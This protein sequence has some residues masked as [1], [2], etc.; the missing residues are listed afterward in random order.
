[1]DVYRA[2]FVVAEDTAYGRWIRRLWRGVVSRGDPL[3][4]LLRPRDLRGEVAAWGRS[5]H[6]TVLDALTV[7]DPEAFASQVK[8]VCRLCAPPTIC[9][10]RLGFWGS[11]ALVVECLS[12][13][14]QRI[15]GSLVTTTRHLIARVPLADEE[16]QK[17]EWWIVKTGGDV[18]ANLQALFGARKEYLK[19]GA[20]PL[21]ASRHFRVGFLVRLWKEWNRASRDRRDLKAKQLRYFLSY[22]EP[23]WYGFDGHLHTTIV[24][25]IRAG[26]PRDRSRQLSR[27]GD[28]IWPAVREKLGP[29]QPGYLAIMG[30]DPGNQV[31]VHFFDWLT[32]SYV[33]ETRP[34]FRVVDRAQFFSGD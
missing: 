4:R 10:L 30:E 16:F 13:A 5:P 9:P 33:K 14:L 12:D 25:G 18:K 21:P 6:W 22:G 32:E 19:A 8:A 7:T 24:S 34:V 29:Y 31:G 23:H 2:V 28:A 15:Y 11:T 17:A 1:M 27:F 20:P 26:D 3:R